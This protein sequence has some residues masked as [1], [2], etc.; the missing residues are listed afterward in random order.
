MARGYGDPTGNEYGAEGGNRDRWRDE[1]RNRS[2]SSRDRGEDRGFFER[3]GEEIRSWFGDEDDDRNR[4]RG[5]WDQDR[6]RGYG[7]E[8]QQRWSQVGS[9][10]RHGSSGRYRDEDRSSFGGMAQGGFDRSRSSF[11]RNR[12]RESSFGSSRGSSSY[13]QGRNEW[14]RG[15][16]DRNPGRGHAQSWG[17]ANRGE[18]EGSGYGYTEFGGTLGGFGNQTFGTSEHDH[19]RSWRD[20]QMQQLDNDYADYCRER[21]Q[22]FHSDF[23][24]WRQN[25]PQGQSQSR[26]Q[27]QSQGQGSDE[28]ILGGSTA[29]ANTGAG[30]AIGSDKTTGQST[31]SDTTGSN[32]TA[33]SGSSSRSGS[34]SRSS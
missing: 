25:R 28:L 17:E 10:E 16:Q 9:S 29:G 12:D 34:R 14:D 13:G 5:S 26:P 32:E 33:G 15:S 24:S 1:D 31:M 3:A 11:D 2:N 23:D 30:S 7:R 22:K 18:S 21:Q 20:K 19:Y 6:N 8:Q 27:S 4:E